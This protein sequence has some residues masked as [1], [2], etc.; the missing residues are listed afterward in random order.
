[1]RVL[2]VEDERRLA[3]AVKRGLEAEGFVVDLAHDGVT[4][5]H[6]ARGGGYDSVVLDI[7]LPGMSGYK[8]CQELRAAENWVP[9]LVLSAKD[10]EYDQADALDLGADD[11]LTKPFSYIVLAARLRALLRRGAVPRPAVL[12]CGDLS[13]DPSSRE[14]RRGPKTVSLTAREFALLEFLMRRAGSVVP[15]SELLSHV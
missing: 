2:V 5:L 11:Y 4:G 6:R 14:V 8:V 10:G 12:Q 1:M 9:V 3:A 15:K 13:L 7:M